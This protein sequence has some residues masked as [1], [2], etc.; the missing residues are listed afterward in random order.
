L[1]DRAGI[2]EENNFSKIVLKRIKS[3]NLGRDAAIL[4]KGGC[5]MRRG[6]VSH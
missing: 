3:L 4:E 1:V 6:S 2:E 5:L